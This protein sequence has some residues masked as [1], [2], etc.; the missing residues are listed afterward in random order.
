MWNTGLAWRISQRFFPSLFHLK[1]DLFTV[2]TV[3][4]AKLLDLKYSGWTLLNESC[5]DFRTD[6]TQQSQTASR[7]Q[8]PVAQGIQNQ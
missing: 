1:K 5:S 4:S 8:I 3:L 7:C 2:W 6:E